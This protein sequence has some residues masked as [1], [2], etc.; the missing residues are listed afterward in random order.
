MNIFVLNESPIL[1]ARDHCDKH[2][3]KMILESAQ[4]LCTAHWL[5]WQS[6]LKPDMSSF[7]RNSYKE[8]LH[9]QVD[10][11]LRPPWKMTHVSHPCT[12]WAQRAWGNYMWLSMHGMELCREYTRRYGRVHK[13]EEVHRWLNRVIPPTFE[14][15][16]STPNGITPFAVA[17]PEKYKVQGDPV[18]SY[19]AYYVGDKSRFAKWKS[20]NIPV[21]WPASTY[22]VLG[23]Q[24]DT[25]LSNQTEGTV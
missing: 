21:W 25:E 7:S 18:A 23:G 10:P 8:W 3:C 6:M 4:M 2:I 17:M 22:L 16:T 1:A 9:D 15:T 5:G 14:G 24:H 13:A 11:R 20:G 19:R 12:Q